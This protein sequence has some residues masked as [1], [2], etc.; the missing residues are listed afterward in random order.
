MIIVAI[1]SG[2]QNMDVEVKRQV[3][4]IVSEF[5]GTKG[6][7]Y[8]D[9]GMHVSSVQQLGPLHTVQDAFRIVVGDC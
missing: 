8:R 3:N 4:L 5:E 1:E 6:Q 9:I 2:G 7:T